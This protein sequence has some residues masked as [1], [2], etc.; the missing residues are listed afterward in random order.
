MQTEQATATPRVRQRRSSGKVE[1]KRADRKAFGTRL[2]MARQE[3]GLTLEELSQRIGGIISRQS[4]CKYELGNMKP[5]DEVVRQ[6]AQALEVSTDYLEGQGLKVD[7]L[8][9]RLAAGGKLDKE[10]LQPIEAR[11]SCWAEKYFR[12]ERAARMRNE[13]KNPLRGFIIDSKQSAEEAARL[14][15][16]KWELGAWPIVSVMNLLETQGIKIKN[17][18]LPEGTLG[19]STKVDGHP[20]IALDFSRK[21]N[22]VERLRITALHELC[23]LLVRIPADVDV[24][25]LCTHFAA[26]VLLPRRPFCAQVGERRAVLTRK[27]VAD[28]HY[29]NGISSRAI[30]HHA[31]DLG[32]ITDEHYNWWYDEVLN[33]DPKEK[34]WASYP[35]N[36]KPTREACI[37]SILE[38]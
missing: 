15:R 7:P 37:D 16:Q 19:L 3:A 20:V 5:G 8:A 26:C 36:D 35:F 13:F 17:M 9:L 38:L 21:A 22:T 1:K 29:R 33:K 27:E 30:V 31:H 11:L 14:L 6:L 24:E 32:I 10:K 23:H 4:I 12:K 25:R 2:Q 28:I 18:P 34:T